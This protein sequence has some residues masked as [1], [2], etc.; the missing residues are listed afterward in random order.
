MVQLVMEVYGALPLYLD[1][2]SCFAMNMLGCF[3]NLQE[4]KVGLIFSLW[5]SFCKQY[6]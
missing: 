2:V 3:L 5:N 4:S 1:D 6:A